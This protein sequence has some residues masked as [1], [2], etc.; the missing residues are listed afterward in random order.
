MVS[1][2]CCCGLWAGL[3]SLLV[4]SSVS[5]WCLYFVAALLVNGA[6]KLYARV[7]FHVVCLPSFWA[8]F[9]GRALDGGKWTLDVQ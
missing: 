7:S 5:Y 3:F 6:I 8:S 9:S 2:L 1:C 4:A